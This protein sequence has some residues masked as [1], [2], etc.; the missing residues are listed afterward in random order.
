MQYASKYKPFE[1]NRFFACA[2]RFVSHNCWLS[3][4]ITFWS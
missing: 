2:E 3:L 4:W 1:A